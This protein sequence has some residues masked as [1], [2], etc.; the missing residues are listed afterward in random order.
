ML[1]CIICIPFTT[2]QIDN[3]TI[4]PPPDHSLAATQIE[5]HEFPCQKT[6]STAAELG[7]YIKI[8]V[9]SWSQCSS[10]VLYDSSKTAE[11]PHR[12][13]VKN[14]EQSHLFQAHPQRVF[15]TD[16]PQQIHLLLEGRYVGSSARSEST[17]AG[18]TCFSTDQAA[19]SIFT[20]S[21]PPASNTLFMWVVLE[22]LAVQLWIGLCCL[23]HHLR[24]DLPKV[25]VPALNDINSLLQVKFPPD[26]LILKTSDKSFKL[27]GGFAWT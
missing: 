2:K 22:F 1:L 15:W 16:S 26:E 13:R 14:F 21:I 27:A 23:P 6:R 3:D 20:C 8:S 10:P 4:S 12:L 17:V 25:L 11:Y 9:P 18:V 24:G 5:H 19:T 7:A